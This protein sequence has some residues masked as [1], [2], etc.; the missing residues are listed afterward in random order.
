MIKI[1]WDDGRCKNP[2]DCHKC[3]DA[4]PEGVLM[5]CPRDPRGRGKAAADWAIMPVFVSLCTGCKLC[6]HICPQ[7]ALVVNVLE[8]A[9]ASG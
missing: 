3:L 7:E 8:E 4:C 1:D 6:A 2:L 9:A 5:T